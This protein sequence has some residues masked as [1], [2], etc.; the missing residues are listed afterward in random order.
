MKPGVLPMTPKQSDRVLNGLVRHPIGRKKNTEIPKVPHQDQVDHF[1]GL[2]RRSAQRIRA[3]WAEFYKGVMNRI[4][5]RNQ[6][7][8]TAAF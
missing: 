5:R 4:Q 3:R 6:R 8:R 7:V 2:S 1:F